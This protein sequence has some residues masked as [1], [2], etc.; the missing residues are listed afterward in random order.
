MII[1]E[2]FCAVKCDRCGRI[3][4][5]DD[6]SFWSE[7]S[8]AIDNANE[9]D[10]H[11][12]DSKHYCQNCFT[13]NEETDEVTIKEPY[14]ESVKRIQKFINAITKNIARVY[15]KDDRFLIEFNEFKPVGIPEHNWLK[16][17]Y[18]DITIDR[19]PISH[20]NKIIITVK[21]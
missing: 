7:E 9:N 6:M 1:K 19:I 18:P 17:S 3:N 16:S 4:Y 15:E 5:E 20:G 10:W 2:I 11:I 14:P 8:I 21:K 13:V 12:L